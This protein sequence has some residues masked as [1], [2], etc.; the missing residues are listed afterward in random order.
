M[1]EYGIHNGAEG[2]IKRPMLEIKNLATAPLADIHTAFADAFSEYEVPMDISSAQLQE[3]LTVRS[4]AADLSL[5]YFADGV[6]AGFILIGTRIIGGQESYYDIATGVIRAFQSR[7]VGNELLQALIQQIEGSDT[8][9]F[10]LEVLQN[11]T[12]AQKLYQKN[13]FE[14]TRRLNCYALPT[15]QAPVT[16]AAQ[17][18]VDAI[19]FSAMVVNEVDYCT[20]QPS[21]Q[22]A[23][24]SYDNA[25]DEHC[26]RTLS[27][28]GNLLAYGIVHKTRGR[29]LQIGLH[30]GARTQPVLAEIV[31]LLAA[32]TTAA[33]L[34]YINVEADSLIEPMLVKLGF[35]NET[36]QYEMAYLSRSG[37]AS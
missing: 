2:R 30:P 27:A 18:Q 31:H 22:N 29:I 13:G 8:E 36:N 17:H 7:G 26:L 11:N 4:Y 37:S 35:G 15:V 21:W 34:L 32:A 20:F 19:D 1:V 24:A 33:T 25:Q 14:I 16:L 9:R 28:D 3:M 10:L 23:L 12:A 5:G 6:L